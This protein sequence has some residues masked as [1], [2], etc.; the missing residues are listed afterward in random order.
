MAERHRQYA[1][2]A[3]HRVHAIH[4]AAQRLLG[5]AKRADHPAIPSRHDG[6]GAPLRGIGDQREKL[7]RAVADVGVRVFLVDDQS[8][9]AADHGVGEMAVQV[10]LRA[11]RHAITNDRS[12]ARQDVAFA[13]V[14]ALRG[15]GAVQRQEDHVDRHRPAQILE[16]LLAQPLIRGGDDAPAGFRVGAEALGHFPAPRLSLLPPDDELV[17]AVVRRETGCVAM[18]EKRVGEVLIAGRDRCKCIRLRIESRDESF[19][20]MSSAR[21]TARW[22]RAR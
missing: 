1:I 6:M 14:H 10:K 13:I 9:G 12:R 2:L 19:Q 8:G 11:H 3:L 20:A 21:S 15:H 17:G 18:G 22:Q 16:Q 4:E 5:G 7:L